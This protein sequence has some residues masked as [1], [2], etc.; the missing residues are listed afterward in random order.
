VTQDDIVSPVQNISSILEQ[1]VSDMEVTNLST[2][3]V[4]PYKNPSTNIVTSFLNVDKL[5]ELATSI[6]P[7]MSVIPPGVKQNV[8]FDIDD[9]GNRK[10][11]LLRKH[12]EYPDDSGAWQQGKN[13]TKPHYYIKSDE[14]LRYVESS[15]GLY[16][17]RVK[18]NFIPFDPQPDPS[19]LVVCWRKYSTLARCPA[20]KKRV[21]WFD[22]EPVL[23]TAIVEYIGEYQPNVIH[24]NAKQTTVPYRSKTSHQ[25]QIIR[26]GLQNGKPPAKSGER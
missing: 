23:S 21:T 15:G 4:H 3:V 16:G 6:N 9:S 8:Y 26:Q 14:T 20:Y 2:D 1:D 13:S 5:Y 19:T 12:S 25:N 22:C 18:K 24:G 7:T 17:K 10:R 11:R